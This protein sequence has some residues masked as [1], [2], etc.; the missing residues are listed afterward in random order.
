[1][2]YLKDPTTQ[3]P[4]PT[5]TMAFIGVSAALA[6]LFLA[7]FV[8]CGVKFSEFTGAD[9]ALVVSPFL[10]LIAHKRQVMA[11]MAKKSSEQEGE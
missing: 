4:S 8:C 6:K 3:E 7:G 5:L 11:S 2:F 10:A 9:F 1:M